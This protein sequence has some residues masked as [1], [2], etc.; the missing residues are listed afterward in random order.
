MFTHP[1]KK[2]LFMGTE[3]GQGNEWN[4]ANPIDWWVLEYDFHRGLKQMVTDLNRLYHSDPVLHH[5]EFE[6]QGFEWIDCHDA[7]QSI[8][9]YQRKKDDD[10]LVVV[11]NFTPVPRQSYRIGVPRAGR[12]TEIFNS[13][14]HYY[15]GSGVGNGGIDLIAEEQPWM[16]H[17]YSITITVPPLG[18]LVLRPEPPPEPVLTTT[19]LG[20]LLADT[21]IGEE[22]LAEPAAKPLASAAPDAVE[23]EELAQPE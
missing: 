18:G 3:F 8:L 19:A 11:V 7:E 14:S 21:T 12:Y 20:E 15:A 1:G 2:L 10:F 9:S 6:W 13:D 4:S 23:E 22:P 17:P 5:Y 16:E